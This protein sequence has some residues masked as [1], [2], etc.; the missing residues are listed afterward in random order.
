MNANNRALGVTLTVT[1]VGGVL[2][3]AACERPTE[4]QVSNAPPVAVNTNDTPATQSTAPPSAPL[5]GAELA[6]AESIYKANCATCH[7]TTGRGEHHHRKDGIP[8][9]TDASWHEGKT[10]GS[11]SSSIANGGGGVMPAFAEKLSG[12]DIAL[13]VRYI[14][15]FPSTAQPRASQSSRTGKS[16]PSPAPA[17]AESGHSGHH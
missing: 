7:L 15:R 3:G 2:L 12:S 6:R 16:R 5:E 11:L 17:P 13:L 9:F 10:D 8:D 4:S 14:H 1:L